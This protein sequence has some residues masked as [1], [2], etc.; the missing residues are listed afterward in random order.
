MPTKIVPSPID[1]IAEGVDA[2]VKLAICDTIS[3]TSG[4][5][6]F[7]QVQQRADD[8]A[9]DTNA[10]KMLMEMSYEMTGI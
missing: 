6:F 4:K 7:K 8:S 1:S 10:R 3:E 2:V 5:Y 9:Y